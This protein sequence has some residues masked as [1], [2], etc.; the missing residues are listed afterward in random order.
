M[1]YQKKMKPAPTSPTKKYVVV[2]VGDQRGSIVLNA[3]EL[4]LIPIYANKFSLYELGAEVSIA[5]KIE[6]VPK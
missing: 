6:V 5:H 4:H 2:P 1:A 3:D